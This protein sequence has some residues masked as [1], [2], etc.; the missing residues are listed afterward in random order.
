MLRG[1]FYPVKMR[2]ERSADR[3][4]CKIILPQKEAAAQM[5]NGL[6]IKTYFIRLQTAS[7]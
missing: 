5:H 4:K 6:S 1:Y 2:L 3:D 7:A